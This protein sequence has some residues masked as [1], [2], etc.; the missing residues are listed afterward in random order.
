MIN[1]IL[2]ELFERDL[3]KLKEELSLYKEERKIWEIKGEIKNCA[4]NLALH[5]LGN[6][7]HF[8]G[9]TLGATDYVRNRDTEFSE[10]N[11]PRSEITNNIDKTTKM[12]RSVLSRLSN[13]DLEKDYPIEVLKYK[14]K[15]STEFFLIHLIG[16]LNYHLGQVNYHRRLI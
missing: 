16:H 6:L 7:N 5:L 8:I 13:A 1:Q 10:K 11:V 15:M 4:G 9:A 14:G 12:I 2:I 3:L